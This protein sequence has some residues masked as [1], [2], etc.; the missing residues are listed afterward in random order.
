M[1]RLKNLKTEKPKNRTRNLSKTKS[2]KLIDKPSFKFALGSYMYVLLA[3]REHV[4]NSVYM[5]KEIRD[6][7]F[8]S[9]ESTWGVNRL[10]ITHLSL[11]KNFCGINTF[12]RM[13]T[14]RK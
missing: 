10:G 6:L 8:D 11:D 14:P 4:S 7:Y 12:R 2:L 1:L 9:P 5:W 13:F 3:L